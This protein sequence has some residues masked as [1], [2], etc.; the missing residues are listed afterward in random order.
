MDPK[1]LFFLLR[2]PIRVS[3]STPSKSSAASGRRV[4]TVP[5]LQG[6]GL[7]ESCSSP[8][9]SFFHYSGGNIKNSEKFRNSS[10]PMCSWY[11]A[12]RR[13]G[14]HGR[15]SSLQPA[16]RCM[17]A[18]TYAC[19]LTW[20]Y[21]RMYVCMHVLMC[22]ASRI[23]RICPPLR[24]KIDA[25]ASWQVK[26]K[27]LCVYPCVRDCMYNMYMRMCMCRR[28]DVYASMCL[29]VYVHVCMCAWTS[30]C[31][32]VCL[33]ACVSVCLSACLSARSLYIHL[34]IW[35]SL[36]LSIYLHVGVLAS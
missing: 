26:V 7:Y 32:S 30:G 33:S 1:T 16:Y 31:P 5:G 18:W 24:S 28:V 14:E 9:G 10:Y 12:T 21:V 2:T 22:T 8:R 13:L 34:H 17:S 27:Y 4:H 29:C 20:M 15:Q 36:S 35:L 3:G 6:W 19:Q 23:F 11:P 25:F